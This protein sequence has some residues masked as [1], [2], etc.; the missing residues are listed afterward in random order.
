M[1]HRYQRGSLHTACPSAQPART[2]F[3]IGNKYIAIALIVIGV[4]L[5]VFSFQVHRKVYFET[6]KESGLDLFDQRGEAD[7]TIYSTFS[8]VEFYEGKLYFTFDP[9]KAVGKIKCPT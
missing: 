6:V 3:L 8:G 9:T 4:V 2:S 5:V 1:R 7:M